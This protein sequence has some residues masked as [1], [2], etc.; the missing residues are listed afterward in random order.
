VI[1]ALKSDECLYNK[2]KYWRVY[3]DITVKFKSVNPAYVSHVSI[4]L[5]EVR[6]GCP[7]IGHEGI[8]DTGGIA[9]LVFKL[10]I[11]WMLVAI[12][13]PRPL[14]SRSKNIRNLLNVRLCGKS[15]AG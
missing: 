9:P 3:S 1:S 7:Y 11:T 10:G 13:A 5:L 15:A 2:V 8:C 6:W 4:L 14:D 12:I